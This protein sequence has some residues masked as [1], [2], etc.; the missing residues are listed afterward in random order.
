M[1]LSDYEH[2]LLLAHCAAH[3]NPVTSS[4]GSDT[5]SG[6]LTHILLLVHTVKNEKLTISVGYSVALLITGL[7]LVFQFFL[8]IVELESHL[9]IL[10]ELDFLI[11]LWK[12]RSCGIAF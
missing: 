2:I 8:L 7:F 5:L 6:L 10:Y 4:R 11:S 12:Q 1:E 3:S 9:D